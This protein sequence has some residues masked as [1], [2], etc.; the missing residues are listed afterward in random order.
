MDSTRPSRSLEGWLWTGSLAGGLSLGASEGWR[1]EGGQEPRGNRKVG[2]DSE[3]KA[4]DM[5]PYL[6]DY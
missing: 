6:G 2:K 3:E 5:V 4:G 1:K